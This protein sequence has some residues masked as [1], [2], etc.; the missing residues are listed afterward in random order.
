MSRTDDVE[1]AIEAWLVNQPRGTKVNVSDL[2][3][4][5]APGISLQVFTGILEN[6]Q[7]EVN[8]CCLVDDYDEKGRK[9]LLLKVY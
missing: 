3:D 6:V 4:R 5:L 7:R 9:N 8:S 1:R 2:R